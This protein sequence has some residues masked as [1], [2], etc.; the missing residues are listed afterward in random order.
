MGHGWDGVG[1]NASVVPANWRE[2]ARKL[3]DITSVSPSEKQMRQHETWHAPYWKEI[4]SELDDLF[5][6]PFGE[7]LDESEED[8]YDDYERLEPTDDYQVIVS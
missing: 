1:R 3:P 6:E 2:T 8:F 4:E 5:D 7:P